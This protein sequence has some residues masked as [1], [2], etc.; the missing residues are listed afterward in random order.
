MFSI[1]RYYV[2]GFFEAICDF[3]NSC[4]LADNEMAPYNLTE[5]MESLSCAA[6]MQSRFAKKSMAAKM[7]PWV[8]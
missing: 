3:H 4:N 7:H 8:S 2:R 6:S 1:I 5:E